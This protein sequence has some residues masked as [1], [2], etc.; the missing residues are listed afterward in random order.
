METDEGTMMIHVS[1]QHTQQSA[2]INENAA[3]MNLK[4]RPFK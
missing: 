2:L 1:L 4:I 3:M